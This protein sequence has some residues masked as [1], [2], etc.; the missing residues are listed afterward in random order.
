MDPLDVLGS[1]KK[2][3]SNG[4]WWDVDRQ[5]VDSK[6]A[7]MSFPFEVTTEHFSTNLSYSVYDFC[8]YIQTL[9]AYQTWTLA[10][11]NSE[12]LHKDVEREF[13]KML[14]CQGLDPSSRLDV[15]FPYFTISTIMK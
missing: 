2:P 13:L 1:L 3:G 7:S 14:S 9:S 10:H 8:K 4:C 11:P 5:L 12:A 15:Q 6:Y